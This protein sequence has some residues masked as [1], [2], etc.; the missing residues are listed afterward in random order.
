MMRQSFIDWLKGSVEVELQGSNVAQFL[1]QATQD[2]LELSNIS[3]RGSSTVHFTVSVENFFLLRKYVRASG[4][5]LKL[6]R[7]TGFPF[8][9]VLLG[10]RMW[11]TIG[12]ALF[13]TVIFCLSSLVWSID[14]KGNKVIPS[15]IIMDAAKK[16]GLYRFQWSFRLQDAD[17]LSKKLVT[18]LPGTTW[19]GVEKVGTKVNIQVVE[20]TIPEAQ[21]LNN[22]RHLVATKDAVISY[23]IAQQGKPMVKKNQ[24]VKTGDILISGIIG[25]EAHSQIVV[26][27]GD[28]KGLV[29]YE[30]E[31]KAPL[32]QKYRVFTGERQARSYIVL[33]KRALKVKGYNQEP[34]SKSEVITTT[35]MLT[36]GK[37]SLPIGK[38][39]EMEQ[40]VAF[41]ERELSVEEA[42]TESLEQAR[43]RILAHAGK[44]AEIVSEIVLHEATENGKVVMKVL[45][46]V[47]QNITKELPIVQMQGD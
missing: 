31:V 47:N 27:Q 8:L 19:I 39:K 44:D 2:K 33:G 25:S 26:A 15:D 43:L 46:E 40:E 22:P 12:I 24:R 3:W 29:W 30:Y 17:V 10:K 1:N 45:Y 32:V 7:K 36:L 35:N 21:Q 4:G 42:K 13:F 34:Y 11:F 6:V 28:V 14:I 5:K 18:A 41:E 9:L 20:A 37:Y 16:E 23:I 38:M